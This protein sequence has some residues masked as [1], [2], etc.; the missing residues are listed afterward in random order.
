MIFSKRKILR[1][2]FKILNKVNKIPYHNN[3]NNN[4][5]HFKRNNLKNEEL[6]ISLFLKD[7]RFYINIFESLSMKYLH[8]EF[9]NYQVFLHKLMFI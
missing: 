3:N 8:N 5:Y 9:Y 1:N 6:K 4:R 7:K 2:P